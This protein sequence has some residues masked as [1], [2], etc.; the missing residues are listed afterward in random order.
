[1]NYVTNCQVA[2]VVLGV[3][4]GKQT[5]RF[6]INMAEADR[7][8]VTGLVRFAHVRIIHAH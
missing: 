7:D 8:D 4:V 3:V 1:M 2:L 5:C 6:K